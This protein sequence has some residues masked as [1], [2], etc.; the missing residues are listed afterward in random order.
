M[1][2]HYLTSIIELRRL[3]HVVQPFA[4]K[5]YAEKENG[6]KKEFDCINEANLTSRVN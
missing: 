5:D 1:C 6:N 4:P 3:D 2:F